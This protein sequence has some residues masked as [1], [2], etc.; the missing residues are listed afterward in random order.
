MLG[1][2]LDQPIPPRLLERV[3]RVRARRPELRLLQADTQAPQLAANRCGAD[4]PIDDPGLEAGLCQQPQGPRASE[5]AKRPRTLVY[6]L[7]QA[8]PGGSVGARGRRSFTARRRR[9]ALECGRTDGGLPG[10]LA[11][12]LTRVVLQFLDPVLEPRDPGLQVGHFSPQ[13]R[14]QGLGLRRE[15]VPEVCREWRP[16][17]HAAD[18][19][20]HPPSWPSRGVT[21]APLDSTPMPL[22]P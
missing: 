8:L 7:P 19:G 6:Q 1:G 3:F 16:C 14:D 12:R 13:S 10:R 22:P 4:R 2:H 5:F 18:I 17:V 9:L 11:G 21:H 20:N 15:A